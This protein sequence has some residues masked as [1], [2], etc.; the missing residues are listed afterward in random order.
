MAKFW[1]LLTVAFIDLMVAVVLVNWGYPR[2]AFLFLLMAALL[3]AYAFF[4]APSVQR[5]P[6]G[7]LRQ[8]EIPY[9]GVLGTVGAIA[10]LSSAAY[11]AFI[12]SQPTRP[13]P[14]VEPARVVAAPRPMPAAAPYTPP[15]SFN[16]SASAAAL[17][18]CI[19]AK[20]HASFQSQPCPDGSRQAW[21]R[22][23]TPDR[24]PTTAQRRQQARDARTV[25][26]GAGRSGSYSSGPSS[27][28]PG[29]SVACQSAR[30]ADAAYRRQPLRNITHDGLRRLGD[31]IQEACY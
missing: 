5:D 12:S 4:S 25:Y 8:T 6:R 22:D 20:G 19:D 17:Y 29:S 9:S 23:A 3:G 7:R 18:K 11:V 28:D 15:R 27:A 10:I 16:P 14:R 26:D 24:E 2:A 31:R 1:F 21:V 13:A 30:A